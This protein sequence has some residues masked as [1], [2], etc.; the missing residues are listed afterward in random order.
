MPRTRIAAI[1]VGTNSIHMIVVEQ[2]RHGYRVIDKEKDMV[3]LGR[4]SLEGRPLT[5]EAIER[6]VEAL[7]RMAGIAERW[8]VTEVEAVA[9]SAIREAPN[10]R[11]FISAAQKAAGIRIRVISGEEEADYIY[12]AVRAAIDFHGGTALSIDI[13]GGSVELIVGTADEVFLT[14]S[15][16]VGAL[17]MAQMFS[18]E[19]PSTPAM[20]GQCRHY[21][22][23]RLKKTFARITTLGFDFSVG[24][25]GTIVTLAGLAASS[26]GDSPASGLRWLSR[27]RL[28]DLVDALTPLPAAERARRFAIDERRASTILAGAIV[29]D[30][31][32][33]K[34]ELEQLRASD[35]A[36]REGIVEAILERKAGDLDRKNGSRKAAVRKDSVRRSSVLGL[37]ERSDVERTHAGHVARLALRIFDQT[38]ELHHFRTG[39]RELLEYAALLHEVGMHVSY[40]GHQKHSYY[41]ISHAGLRGFTG[42][43]VAVV[44]NVARYYRKAVPSDEHAHFA[45]LSPVQKEQVRKLAAILRMADALDRG[46]RRAVRDV[47]VQ[48]GSGSLRF[49]VRLR[50]DA[51]VELAAAAKRAK[52][53]GKVF[54]TD[55]DIES[56]SA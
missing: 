33:R 18:L 25:S 38:E 10:G 51:D 22:R 13:G 4:G 15:E 5:D 46:R 48:G 53:F 30:E 24:T 37:V 31:I 43:Q 16:P 44:A 39:E 54:E 41:L 52:Y 26:T 27:K 17:R 2:Q 8:Q 35:T 45:Q 11:R 3:Q 12:R 34:L 36:L 9:T 7:K 49:Q 1:D 14:A 21:V 55:V 29:L 6:G 40:Q 32:M 23:K 50:G 28:H 20:V 42:D 56:S 47:R 19:G